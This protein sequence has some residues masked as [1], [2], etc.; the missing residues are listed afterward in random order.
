MTFI[1]ERKAV[2]EEEYSFHA[3]KFRLSL[4]LY[5]KAGKNRS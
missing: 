4:E 3:L 5:Q 1:P 2:L